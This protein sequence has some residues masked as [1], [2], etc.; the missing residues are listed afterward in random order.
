MS[1]LSYF[2]GQKYYP[3][4]YTVAKDIFYILAAAGLVVVGNILT[5][6]RPGLD[7]GIHMALILFFLFL[8]YVTDRKNIIQLSGR[9]KIHENKYR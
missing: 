4:R 9:L 2:L 7:K 6:G 1:T 3:I 5:T 8:I